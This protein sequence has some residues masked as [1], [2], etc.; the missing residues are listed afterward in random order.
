M[1]VASSLVAKATSEAR[2]CWELWAAYSRS[3]G[4]FKKCLCNQKDGYKGCLLEG[5]YDMAYIIVYA[6]LTDVV[7]VGT[8]SSSFKRAAQPRALSKLCGWKCDSF[9]QENRQIKASLNLD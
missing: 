5:D 9:E 8:C 3:I 4:P 1:V 6:A 7:Q 2:Q